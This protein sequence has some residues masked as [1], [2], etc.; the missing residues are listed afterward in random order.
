MSMTYQFSILKATRDNI[1]MQLDG[2]T[3]EQLNV[4]PPGFNNNLVWHYGHILVTQQLLCYALSGLPTYMDQELV[5]Q[6]RKGTRPESDV[7]QADYDALVAMDAD[8]LQKL[9]DDYASGMFKDYK[10]YTTSYNV[11]LASIEDAIAFNAIHEAHHF[12]SI[13]SMRKLV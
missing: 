12:G 10:S 13:I 6:Y 3:I 7:S 9:K 11:T 8:L 5:N 1:Q 2:L 4:I